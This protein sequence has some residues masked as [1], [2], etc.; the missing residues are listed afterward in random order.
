MI[1]RKIN[2]SC[3]LLS[4]SVEMDTLETKRKSELTLSV[5]CV[6]TGRLNEYIELITNDSERPMRR[7][8]IV[9]NVVK[10]KN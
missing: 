9:A 7:V 4:A 10:S 6:E 3:E 2:A 5:K 8:R 1:I